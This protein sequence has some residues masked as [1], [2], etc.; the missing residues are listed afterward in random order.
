MFAIKLLEM[1]FNRYRKLK[2]YERIHKK[3]VTAH[4]MEMIKNFS[5]DDSA[6]MEVTLSNTLKNATDNI[7]ALT[8][9]K[10]SSKAKTVKFNTS[11]NIYYNPVEPRPSLE[12]ISLRIFR[13]DDD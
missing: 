2:V 13:R 11:A 8:K 7:P 9:A 12:G 6:L 1:C 5:Q 3:F 4:G 10:S